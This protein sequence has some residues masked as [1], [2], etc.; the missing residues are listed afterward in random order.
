[1]KHEKQNCE[2]PASL[3]LT[4]VCFAGLIAIAATGVGAQERRFPVTVQ[5]VAM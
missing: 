1:M 5:Q 3:P 2:E 4:I